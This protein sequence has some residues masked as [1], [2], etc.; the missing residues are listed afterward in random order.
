MSS[1][2]VFN[3]NTFV[4]NLG[5]VLG[6]KILSGTSG[7]PSGVTGLIT[8]YYADSIPQ[9]NA[10]FV[11]T[12][13]TTLPLTT[14]KN[15]E[16]AWNQNAGLS[17][18]D[19]TLHNK[20]LQDF[21][22]QVGYP[23]DW[24]SLIDEGTVNDT[25]IDQYFNNSFDN[26]LSTYPYVST[27][28]YSVL[29]TPGSPGALGDPNA[30]PQAKNNFF[31]NWT[32]FMARTS[33]IALS[34][35]SDSSVPLSQYRVVYEAFF[36]MQPGETPQDVTNRFNTAVEEFVT[37]QVV[38]NGSQTAANGWFIPSQSFSAWFQQMKDQ[39]LAN[40]TQMSVQAQTTAS[41]G[42]AAGLLVIDKILRLLIQLVNILQLISASQ[43][44]QLSFNTNWT[45]AYT[46]L[47]TQVPQFA[48]GAS[49]PSGG[50]LAAGTKR[51]Q[52]FRNKEVNPH[53]QSVLQNVQARRSNIQDLAKSTQT[54]ITQ[55]QD[56]SNQ[57][58]QMG[59]SLI[60][61]LSTILSQIY[62]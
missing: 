55:S 25:I 27:A 23:A 36:P 8:R 62:R 52:G 5:L 53:M 10:I 11:Q 49:G 48:A 29:A 50:L 46:N 45:Q 33:D 32:K 12:N 39:F 15:F 58:T 35:G 40:T 47:M 21:K 16:L 20:L 60:Q 26:F 18:N 61:Q 51:A 22:N 54:T 24:Q 2:T 56:A 57:L 9:G 31:T 28:N 34:S 19:Q 42:T 13:T 37:S 6:K 4:N 1:N 14:L 44:Q 59:T 17:A 3:N 7:D 43:A 38:V 41:S 30:G